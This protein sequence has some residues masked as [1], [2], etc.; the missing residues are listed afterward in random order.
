MRVVVGVAAIVA[1]SLLPCAALHAQTVDLSMHLGAAAWYDTAF[2]VRRM[3]RDTRF[4]QSDAH[5]RSNSF[6]PLASAVLPGSGQLLLGNSRFVGYVAI[7]AL[8]WWKYSKDVSEQRAQE[9]AFKSLARRL[10]RARFTSGPPDLL[11]DADWAYYEHMR[12][13]SESGAYSLAGI[14][15]TVVP[16]TL[17]TTYNGSRWQLAQSTFSSREAAL[18]EYMHD[19][20]RPEFTWSWRSED[21]AYDIFKRTTDKRNDAYRAGVADLM[22]VG[23]NHVLSMID[24]FTTVRLRAVTDA[25]GE[26]RIGARVPW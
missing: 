2:A 19:A 25:R 4:A 10:A 21:F 20:V 1:S 13:Y 6:A 22:V 16:E 9:A 11:P 3:A 7:E 5:A 26:T 14:G 12:D 18:Q 17:T 23:A 24:A 15:G 8:T